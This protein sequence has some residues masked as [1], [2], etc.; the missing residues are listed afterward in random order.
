MLRIGTTL[1]A[2]AL[3]GGVLTA[4]PAQAGPAAVTTVDVLAGPALTD[5]V[6]FYGRRGYGR[7]YYG[8]GF[9]PGFAVGA[10]LGL[11]SA[12][13]F[14]GYGPYYGGYAPVYG[15]R[16]RPYA[17]RPY[18]YY[19]RRVFY[20]P[21]FYPRR[22]GYYRPYGFRRAYYHYPYGAGFRRYYY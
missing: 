4:A 7:G 21:R 15:Y 18:A 5:K 1:V 9:G 17:Y 13:S 3:A 6:G 8:G 2:A 20:G 11:I 22:Y 19:P 16:Y 10:G 12:A 14:G